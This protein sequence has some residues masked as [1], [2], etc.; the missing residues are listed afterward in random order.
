MGIK[1]STVDRL[2]ERILSGEL[3]AG[4][5]LIEADLV[6]LIG[7]SRSAVRTALVELE[8][9]GLI[10]RTENRGASVRRVSLQDAIQITQARRALETLC[11]GQA[12]EFADEADRTELTRVVDEMRTAVEA[13]RALDYS[14]LNKQFHYT[15]S[16][17]GRHAVAA[18]LIVTL[19][20]RAAHHQF[21][22]SLLRGRM[23]ESLAEHEA[24]LAA[25]IAADIKSAEQATHE[26]LE[27]VIATM[28]QWADKGF[29]H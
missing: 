19:R 4:Q 2:R 5:R 8:G 6:E 16:Q 27:S 15:L 29:I 14:Q 12:A 10:D 18:E 13:D 24:I 7:A 20:N 9:E 3:A 23:E 11:A 17:I 25:V 1:S 26:H 22:L 28:K 21:K